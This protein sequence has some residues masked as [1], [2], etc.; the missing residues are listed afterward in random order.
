MNARLHLKCEIEHGYGSG[1]ASYIDAWFYPAKG[2]SPARRYGDSECREGLVI[3]FSI[4]SDYYAIGQGERC[5]SVSGSGGSHYLPDLMM[6]DKVT[7]PHLQYLVPKI[8]KVLDQEFCLKRIGATT[9]SESIPS[10]LRH[11]D[12]T[13][14]SNPPYHVFDALFY[15]YD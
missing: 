2:G 15:W 6:I 5:K 13:N 14:L 7:D 8:E 4:L 1:Y 10:H 3:L 9:L 12:T 11:H